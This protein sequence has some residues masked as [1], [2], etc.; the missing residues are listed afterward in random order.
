MDSFLR[1]TAKEII[2]RLNWQQLSRTT[3]V[4][5]SHR[6]GLV[7]KNELLQLQRDQNQ[8]A[9]WAPDVKT[10]Q[11]LAQVFG[12]EREASVCR[13]ISKLHDTTHHGTLGELIEH[14]T[15]EAPRG[16]I[17]I[18]VAGKESEAHVKV[19]KYA[20]FKNKYGQCDENA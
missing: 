8:K 15:H 10:L 14:F 18:V 7:L 9:I 17:V 5:P 6:A 2:K 16:E 3:L 11:Q 13:E 12:Y 19:D 20:K 1:H 4:L